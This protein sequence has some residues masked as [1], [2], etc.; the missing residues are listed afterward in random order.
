MTTAK[1]LFDLGYLPLVKITPH[2]ARIAP[3]S[4][5][6][7]DML[8]KVPGKWTP[9]GWV[10]YDWRAAD[11]VD[12]DDVAA[13]GSAGVGIRTDFFP[14]VDI[15]ITD[16]VLSEFVYN[17]A[18]ASLGLTSTRI[19]RAP[20]K[21][22]V[23]RTDESFGRMRL[24]IGDDHLVEILGDGQQFVAGGIHPGTKQPYT[25]PL[26]VLPAAE[27]EV[28]TREQAS[29]FLDALSEDLELF[30]FVTRRE[31][32]GA[33]TADRESIDQR[34][35]SGDVE[36]I[37]VALAMVPN[38]NATFPGRDDYLRV[39]YAIKAA[40]G[41][42]GYEL[43][44]EWA[45][46][47]EGNS[48]ASGND[49]DVVR[50]D[51]DRMQ[52]PFEIG[53]EYIY[54]TARDFGYNQAGDEFAAEP[55]APEEL[56][57]AEA[58]IKEQSALMGG[59]AIKFSDAHVARILIKNHGHELR[60]CPERSQW[61][62]WD[63]AK[64]NLDNSRRA[65]YLS[66]LICQRLVKLAGQT[67]VEQK[68]C[69][70]T[71]QRLSNLGAK[72]AGA[73]YASD[74][75]EMQLSQ[76]LLDTDAYLLN[77]PGGIVDLRD[78]SISA[79]DPLK[80]MTRSTAVAP[81]AGPAPRWHS[82][83]NEAVGGNKELKDYLQRLVGYALTG[84]K[85]EH[86]LAFLYGSGGNGKGV[87]IN[88]VTSILDSYA[89]AA[90]MDT[91]TASKFDRHPTDMAGLAGA[92]LVTAQETQEGRRWDEQKVKT[93]TSNDKVQA[94]FMREDFFE[95]EP[96]FKLVFAGNH[97][98][99]IRNLDDAMRR[100]FHLVPF[101]KKPAKV[102]THLQIE[103]KE[104]WPQ[105]LAWMIEGAQLWFKHGLNA[106]KVVLEATAEYF[107][108]EDPM[109]QWIRDK[110]IFTDNEDDFLTSTALHDNYREWCGDNGEHAKTAKGL[111]RAVRER[112]GFRQKRKADARGF[113]GIRLKDGAG[114]D[115]AAVSEVI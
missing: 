87:F 89:K 77:T 53:A 12:A 54:E 112:G 39:G 49:P 24:W 8:G 71:Q 38:D 6:K 69:E 75:P 34:H 84:L 99:E 51:W 55:L 50:S 41:E 90:S 58:E 1:Q 98:P 18:V 76:V 29:A 16:E 22:M 63:G 5:L 32:S 26:G 13:W 78:G 43:F 82:F 79:H 59:A 104:E 4:K 66:G 67:I 30:G 19:G 61:M 46:K 10:G 9:A 95:F 44:A 94:R 103:L 111:V 17:R 40:I 68:K 105:I 52:P 28:L 97:K 74:Q 107:E 96:N 101:T 114:S 62:S 83:L 85:T 93:L 109:G 33:A 108:E 14:A 102:N 20:K 88:T 113:A 37:R 2:D 42:D 60:Y 31:G 73:Q 35:L 65:T 57:K 91:F 15:D 21:L 72:Q 81:S 80:Y 64:W 70:A 86:N 25:W 27:L 11:D 106:P 47:W 48:N 110:V 92:R 56:A 3:T 100:R 7:P 115:F 45:A 36:R 23:Y